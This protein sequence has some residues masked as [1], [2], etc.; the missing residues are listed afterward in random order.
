MPESDIWQ[1]VAGECL[2]V[3]PGRCGTQHVNMKR[4]SICL[5]LQGPELSSIFISFNCTHPE[6]CSIYLPNKP[7]HRPHHA[8]A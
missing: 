7:N 5:R 1:T 3:T 8:P 6:R 2:R 4:H